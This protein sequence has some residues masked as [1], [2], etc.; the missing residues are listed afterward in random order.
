MSDNLIGVEQPVLDHGYV[1]LVERWGSDEQIVK[2]ARMSTGGGLKTPEQDERF[3]DY[4][5]R[6]GHHS[7]FE[8]A[9]VTVEMKLPIFVARQFMRHR[10][11]GWNEYSGRYSQ[12]VEDAY[13]PGVE[14]FQAQATDN[15]QG[16]AG[17]I[18]PELAEGLRD[19]M[20][21][22]QRGARVNYDA[23]L[24]RGVSRE[25]A[26]VNLPLSQYTLV[27]MT[28]NLRNLLHLIHLRTHPH[29]QEEAREYAQVLGYL[30]DR[31]FPW[32]YRAFHEWTQKAITLGAQEQVVLQLVLSEHPEIAEEIRELARERMRKSHY[33]EFVKKLGLG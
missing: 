32:T 1:K 5:W 3:I 19:M 6:H 29:A 25:L 10:T 12:M 27:G 11:A 8:M 18:D 30:V 24:T 21:E 4:L 15:R 7:P 26:R 31:L 22:E 20:R 23:Y 33:Q 16:S 2:M 14:R 17:Q 13:L 9:G 28:I